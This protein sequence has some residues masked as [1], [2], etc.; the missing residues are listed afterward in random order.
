MPRS[1]FSSVIALKKLKRAAR[2]SSLDFSTL[3]KRHAILEA[4]YRLD[5]KIAPNLYR[6]LA[7]VTR[8]TTG[9]LAVDGDGQPVEW[10]LEMRRLDQNALFDHL[11]ERGKLDGPSM[12]SLAGVVAELHRNADIRSGGGYEAMVVIVDGD[13]GDLARLIQ[14]T[15]DALSRHRDLL[16]SA[17][18]DRLGAC[19]YG[20][21][22]ADEVYHVLARHAGNLLRAGRTVIA[23]ATFLAPND[24]AGIE[25]VAQDLGMPFHGI[26]LDASRS[27]LEDRVG[28]RR[29]DLSDAT[30]EV[31]AKQLERN[32]GAKTWTII[33]AGSTA[34]QVTNDVQR[35]LPGQKPRKNHDAHHR[36]RQSL[37]R[38]RQGTRGRR[39]SRPRRALR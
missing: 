33:D 27:I 34:E 36:S 18:T 26:W 9:R 6:G 8:D 11:A 22:Q 5:I 15:R 37:L 17:P 16:T 38:H 30:I 19:A 25:D 10:L 35:Q 3:V 7:A 28:T 21:A 2:Y 20:P 39:Q 1:S 13:A 31:L 14:A 24:R 12:I 29:G 4:E 23:D 32:I